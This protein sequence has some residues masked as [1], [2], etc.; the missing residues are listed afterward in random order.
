M[1]VRRAGNNV[2][3][4]K[5]SIEAFELDWSARVIFAAGSLARLGEEVLRLGAR[6]V[7]VVTD[8]GLVAAGHLKSALSSLHPV[9]VEV[10]V[11]D[12]VNENPTTEDVER[13]LEVARSFAADTMVALGGGSVMDCAKGI[14]F[15]LSNGGSLEAIWRR[16]QKVGSMLPAI[17]IPTTT[18][19][20]S[21]AQSYALIARAEDGVKM[22]CGHPLARFSVVILDPRLT[23]TL[24]RRVLAQ[25][26]IDAIS[27]AL[28]SHV[29]TKSNPVSRLFSQRAWQLLE[30]SF[31]GALDGPQP[32]RHRSRM[33]L[34]SFLAGHAIENSML[35]ATHAAAN[36]LTARYGLTHGIA[37]GLMLPHVI[38]RNGKACPGLY[39]DL[40]NSPA[41]AETSAAE[42]LADRIEALLEKVSFPANLDQVGVGLSDLSQLAREATNQWTGKFNPVEVDAEWFLH[43]YRG[44]LHSVRE[45][46]KA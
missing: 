15:L 34:G 21:E 38:R 32:V 45:L 40:L 1:A 28:E 16:E 25:T 39:G 14:N 12:Q 8:P 44:C 31:E 18:G 36:P 9:E 10:E 4:K 3:G 41:G 22:A 46:C 19:T 42:R 6:R 23:A 26:G 7:L 5:P 30:G 24:S 37:I 2:V 35:G 29:C 13:G 20:G 27:H 33:L 43:L 11:F 17:G